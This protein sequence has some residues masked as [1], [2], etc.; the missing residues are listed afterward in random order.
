MFKG[1]ANLASLV[2]QAQQVGSK[3]QGISDELKAKRVTGAAG[4]GLVEVEVNGLGDVLK[5][6]IDPKLIESRDR[7]MIEDLIPAAV[8]QA[9]VK[10]RALHAEAMTSATTGMDVP[11][12]DEA[13]ANLQPGSPPSEEK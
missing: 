7:E 2:K 13:L 12:L 5:V 10:S 11:G 1:I 9:I 4:G 8:N 3:L 6:R